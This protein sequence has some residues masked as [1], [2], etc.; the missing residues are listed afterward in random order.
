MSDSASWTILMK[1]LAIELR[2]RWGVQGHDMGLLREHVDQ[3]VPWEDVWKER[4]RVS[5][6][7]GYRLHYEGRVAGHGILFSRSAGNPLKFVYLCPVRVIAEN[8]RENGQSD[9][10]CSPISIWPHHLL[11]YVVSCLL[12]GILQGNVSVNIDE[13]NKQTRKIIRYWWKIE[14]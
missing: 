9:F 11:S 3:N 4:L 12:L 2:I 13:K 8:K 14:A 6:D 5:S 10:Y 7:K 1:V